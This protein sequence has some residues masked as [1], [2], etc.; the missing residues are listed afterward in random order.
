MSP[1]VTKIKDKEIIDT[2]TIN[3]ESILFLS[4]DH[5]QY[6]QA[7]IF[8]AQDNQQLQEKYKLLEKRMIEVEYK[9]F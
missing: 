4:H 9:Y 6:R 5:I 8:L 7:I 2:N 1:Y 3:K